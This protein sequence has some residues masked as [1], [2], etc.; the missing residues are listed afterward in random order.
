MKKI[1]PLLILLFLAAPLVAQEDVLKKLD[2]K[3][4]FYGN[5]A[6]QIWANPELGYLETNSS[7]L[8]QKTLSDAGFK[9]TAGV[10]D[11]PTAF[12]AEYG[13]GKPVIGIMAEFDAL[14]GVS[15]AA[16]PFKSP[17]VEGGAGHACGHH[18][19]GAASVAS[20]IAV[21]EWMKENKSKHNFSD[22]Q[23]EEIEANLKKRL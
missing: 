7:V 9:V 6:R 1:L 23:I 2:S 12:M 22:H 18:L 11:I 14:P 16:V 8:L 13:S 10:A 19:F 4:D 5:I 20:G 15:Q 21:M 17:V 3:A